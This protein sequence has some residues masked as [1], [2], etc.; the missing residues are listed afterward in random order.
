MVLR[1]GVSD[2]DWIVVSGV[3][4]VVCTVYP[5]G[6]QLASCEVVYNPRKPANRD[7]TWTGSAWVF[8]NENDFGGYAERYPRLSPYVAKLKRGRGML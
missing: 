4:C 3:D 5:Q 1:P 8:Y 2:G 6:N 7:V